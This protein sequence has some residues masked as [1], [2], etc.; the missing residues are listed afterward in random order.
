MCSVTYKMWIQIGY[1]IYLLQL[2]P[3]Q[4]KTLEQF[5]QQHW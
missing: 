1:R 4:I 2:Q 5:L 3:R